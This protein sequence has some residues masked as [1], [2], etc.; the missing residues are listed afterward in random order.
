MEQLS[1]LLLRLTIRREMA[2]NDSGLKFSSSSHTLDLAAVSIVLMKFSTFCTVAL[3]M[4]ADRSTA[5]L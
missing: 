4:V 5:S 3:R 2:S 1:T